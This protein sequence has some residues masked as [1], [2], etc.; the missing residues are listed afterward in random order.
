[1]TVFI[2]DDACPVK[3]IWEKNCRGKGIAVI[4]VCDT[5]HIINFEYMEIKVVDKGSGSADIAIVN[6][7]KKSDIVITQDYGVA[8]MALGKGS[9]VLHQSGMEYTHQNIE[10]LMEMRHVA[11]EF[12]RKNSKHHLKGPKKRTKEDDE[13]F[14]SSFL[15]ILKKASEN[16]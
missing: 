4:A 7:C 14:T 2:V 16:T 6:L 3:G 12:R 10:N 11:S 13:R 8:S 9:Y 15:A 1:M 5:S